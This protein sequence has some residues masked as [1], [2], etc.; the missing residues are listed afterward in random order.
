MDG[1]EKRGPP[2]GLIFNR[3]AGS[4]TLFSFYSTE[5]LAASFHWT[6]R[7]LYCFMGNPTSLF[8]NSTC[9]LQKSPLVSE[10]DRADLITL[11]REFTNEMSFNVRL[12]EIQ[13]KG[14]D[15]YQTQLHATREQQIRGLMRQ[16]SDANREKKV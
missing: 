1:T 13:R 11:F 16:K 5:L 9:R 15:Y 6:A 2:L 14:Y 8:K 3:R 4:H 10:E 12:K 7:N